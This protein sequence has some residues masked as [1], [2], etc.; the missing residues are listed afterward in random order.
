M[1]DAAERKI[2]KYRR[3]Y[4]EAADTMQTAVTEAGLRAAVHV[5]MLE[6]GAAS[7][8][9]VRAEVKAQGVLRRLVDSSGRLVLS[10]ARSTLADPF[11]PGSFD[12]AA[13]AVGKLLANAWQL[14]GGGE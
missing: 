11:A 13:Y 7:E 4:D 6:S 1:I 9:A 12:A 8:Q 5:V 14:R 3:Q 2:E 10:V